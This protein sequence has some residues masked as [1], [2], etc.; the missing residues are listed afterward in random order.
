MTFE[1]FEIALDAINNTNLIIY[2]I[3]LME[4]CEYW[5]P[6]Y[7]EDVKE[8]DKATQ[9]ELDDMIVTKEEYE[10]EVMMNSKD[11]LT[12]QETASLGL[13]IYET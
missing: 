1:S 11:E 12:D 3:K 6:V 10:W 13:G 7:E 9:Q 5:N 4:E 2:I 8:Y